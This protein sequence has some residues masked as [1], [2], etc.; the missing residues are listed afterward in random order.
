MLEVFYE[1]NKTAI[2]FIVG[3][4]LLISLILIWLIRSAN[5]DWRL[6]NLALYFVVMIISLLHLSFFSNQKSS[7]KS[8]LFPLLFFLVAI[9]WPLAT[10]LQLTQWLQ[11]KIS[12]IIVDILLLLEHEAKLEGTVID[13]GIFGK[14]GVDQACS[15]INGL[16]ASL[17]VSIFVGAYYS[18][19]IIQ[20]I[21]LIAAGLLLALFFNLGRAFCLSFITVKGKGHILE[22]PILSI[23]NY[24]LPNVHDL[25]GYIETGFILLAILVFARFSRRGFLPSTLATR[26][27]FWGNL[28]FRPP[29]AFSVITLITIIF[30]LVLTE[31]HFKSI[32]KGMVPLPRIDL[33]MSG[34]EIIRNDQV[35]SNQVRAQLHFA[36]ATSFQWQDRYR[37][38]WNQLGFPEI[39]LNDEYWQ[40]F[41]ASW[42]SGGACTAVLTTHSPQSCLPLTGLNQVSPAIGESPILIPVIVGNRKIMFE[43]L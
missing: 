2:C 16:Q 29:L 38:R 17:V 18:F 15:G 3:I 37:S 19:G 25:V 21:L 34:H 14:V 8:F 40:V 9:P 30:T 27:N 36:E 22:K 43:G 39:N 26:P 13:V 42:N 4:P 31:F 28:K 20:R 1:K 33:D 24:D 11:E 10:D 6:I 12:N 7:L 5:S 32:E 23:G 41:K 35:I